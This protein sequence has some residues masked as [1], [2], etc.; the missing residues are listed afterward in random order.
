VKWLLYIVL[1]ILALNLLVIIMVGVVLVNDWIRN[2]KRPQRTRPYAGPVPPGDG[3]TPDS[4][5]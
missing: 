3:T 2:R 4:T 1:G 5:G